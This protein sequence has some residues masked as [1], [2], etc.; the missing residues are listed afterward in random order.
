MQLR[1]AGV[2]S[3][4]TREATQLAFHRQGLVLIHQR[5]GEPGVSQVLGGVFARWRENPVQPL[6]AFKMVGD[7]GGYIWQGWPRIH[8]SEKKAGWNL[9]G[10]G[11]SENLSGFVFSIRLMQLLKDSHFKINNLVFLE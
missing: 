1:L 5:R 6:S 3:T 8:V 4:G 2:R 7:S 10:G 9:R 11:K